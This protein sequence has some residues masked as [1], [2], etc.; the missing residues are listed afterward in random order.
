LLRARSDLA[1]GRPREAA[2]QARVALEA[3]IA[4]LPGAGRLHEWR[5][6]VGDLANTALRSEPAEAQAAELEE[7]VR[8][9]EAAVRRHRHRR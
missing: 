3:L 1:A 7:A 2:L 6:P 4:E 5:G 9:M 8:A